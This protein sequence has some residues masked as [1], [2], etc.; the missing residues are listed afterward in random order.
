MQCGEGQTSE[1]A[2]CT[3]KWKHGGTRHSP[4]NL[5]Q[6]VSEYMAWCKMSA[7]DGFVNPELE[8]LIKHALTDTE[9]PSKNPILGMA[10][11]TVGDNIASAQD[12]LFWLHHSNVDRAFM[13]IQTYHREAQYDP[14]W[15]N[16]DNLDA[17]WYDNRPGGLTEAG[18]HWPNFAGDFKS[19]ENC[20]GYAY[21]DKCSGGQFINLLLGDDRTDRYTELGVLHSDGYTNAEGVNAVYEDR[22][23]YCYDDLTAMGGVPHDGPKY[24]PEQMDSAMACD[25]MDMGMPIILV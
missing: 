16:V 2:E 10:I 25:G 9:D 12:P 15:R 21:H 3:C 24:A 18:V 8:D 5:T 11:G 4:C 6:S 13:A 20:R 7:A 19:A 14:N 17:T 22:L 1:D 23:P